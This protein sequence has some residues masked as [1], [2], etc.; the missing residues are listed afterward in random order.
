MRYGR[1]PVCN[2]LKVYPL[3]PTLK[4]HSNGPLYINTVIGSLA[5]D[6]WVVTFGT[7]R[8][9]LDGLRPRTV[10][11]SLYQIPP[12]NGQCPVDGWVVTFGTARRGLDGLRPRPVP[13]LLYQIAPI[14]GQCANFILFDAALQLPLISK[15]LKWRV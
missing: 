15:G 3:I 6:W 1:R 12:I 8:R 4:P 2:A 10:P 14:N 11:Y 13:S 9:G 5:V 7:A